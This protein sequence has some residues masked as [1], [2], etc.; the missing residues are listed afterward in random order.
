MA[1]GG[2]HNILCFR[3]S[4]IGLLFRFN[5]SGWYSVLQQLQLKMMRSRRLKMMAMDVTAIKTTAMLRMTVERVVPIIVPGA[6]NARTA[7]HPASCASDEKEGT[8][9]RKSR[10]R[11]R[12]S[13]AM[14]TTQDTV[15]TAR[16]TMATAAQ[17][18]APATAKAT[19]AVR[20]MASLV[21][22]IQVACSHTAP[23]WEMPL[24]SCT[25][26]HLHPGV[27]TKGAS[28]QMKIAP[29]RHLMEL[30][31]PSLRMGIL[32]SG[33]HF[34]PRQWAHCLKCRL[35]LSSRC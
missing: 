15:V 25:W 1:A 18:T 13:N 6:A 12:R 30:Q 7:V 19:T 9:E 33:Q 23:H 35:A 22:A 11:Q 14:M 26:W 3:T 10:R 2:T 27:A 29:Q 32:H 16:A 21:T 8:Q 17:H 31:P 34:K 20:R 5:A 4:M 28:D 24:P